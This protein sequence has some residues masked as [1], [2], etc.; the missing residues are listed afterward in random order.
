MPITQFEYNETTFAT[1]TNSSRYSFASEKFHDMWILL[2]IPGGMIILTVIVALSYVSIR[3]INLLIK[4][5][6]KIR[7]C[8]L[9]ESSRIEVQQ[10]QYSKP[11]Y[12]T[13]WDK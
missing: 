9:E 10:T 5:C 8:E 3:K 7:Q 12:W 11:I 13:R 1:V 4:N 2:C 6:Q